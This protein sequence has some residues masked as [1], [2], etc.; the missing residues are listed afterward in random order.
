[1]P[2]HQRAIEIFFDYVSPFPY[3]LNE[4]LIKHE[5]ERRYELEVQWT[6]IFLGSL[7]PTNNHTPLN[8]TDPRR[9]R[10]S[11]IEAKRYAAELDV[12]V[13]GN[14]FRPVPVL[15]AGIAAA[16]QGRFRE[17]HTELYRRIQGRGEQPTDALLG[18]TIERVG[19][20]AAT[21]TAAMAAP[22]VKQELIDNA[23]RA[24]QLD[25]FGVPFVFH[26]GEAFWGFSHFRYLLAKLDA[27]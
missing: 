3:L 13:T 24:K 12:P 19:G 26:D 23:E 2:N 8:A 15:R 9:A 10:Y 21:L 5:V 17:F 25:V 7:Y 22:D 18:D 4:Y 11:A 6:P 20:N 1:M 16:R 27:A 14:L